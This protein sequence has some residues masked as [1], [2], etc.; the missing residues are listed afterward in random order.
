MAITGVTSCTNVYGADNT[1][2]SGNGKVEKE[3]ASAKTSAKGTKT[4]S[5][6]DYYS[7][8][9]KNYNCVKNGKVAIS[10][11]YLKECVK[12]ADKAKELEENLDF[13]NEGYQSGYM[14]AK[15]NAA[16][17]GARLVSYSESW[18][19]DNKGN[20]TMMASTTVTSDVKGWKEIK[21][22]QEERIR[23]KAEK[24]KQEEKIKEQEEKLYKDFYYPRFNQTT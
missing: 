21:E 14:S 24:E 23:E 16:A 11:S 18:S 9:Q 5:V 10:G 3:A 15:A 1:S 13:F 4:D 12:D 8:L 7:Y 19:I 6:S 2:Q 20:I 17:I 22:E